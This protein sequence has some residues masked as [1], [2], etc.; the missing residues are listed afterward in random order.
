M[1]IE[2]HQ[3]KTGLF[4]FAGDISVNKETSLDFEKKKDVRL[5]V[6]ADNGHE[7]THCVVV[8]TLL[9]VND[10]APMFKQTYYRTAVWEGQ[11]HNTYIMQVKSL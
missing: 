8:V 7:T 5:V 10:N 6:L 2:R 3:V 9:D 4:A 11:A 1:L